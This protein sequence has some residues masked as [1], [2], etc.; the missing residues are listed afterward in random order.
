MVSTL[1]LRALAALTLMLPLVAG[2]GKPAQEAPAATTSATATASPSVAAATLSGRPASALHLDAVDFLSPQIGWLAA[3][4]GSTA[5]ILRTLTGGA[6]WERLAAGSNDFLSLDFIDPDT[7]WALVRAGSDVQIEHTADGGATWAVQWIGAAADMRYLME[8]EDA[9]I[10]MLDPQNGHA[11]FGGQLLATANGGAA[12]QPVTTL[13]AGFTPTGMAWRD[14]QHGWVAGMSCPAPAGGSPCHVGVLQ[15]SDG[16]ASWASDFTASEA[17]M[18]LAAGA[19]LP[20]LSFPTATQGWLYFKTA[21]LEGR[22]YAT[23]DGGAT[24][25]LEQ[26]NLAGGRGVAGLPVF[27]SPTTGW[28]PRD[29]GAAPQPGGI[30]VTHDSGRTWTWVG[31]EQGWS[32]TA[33]SAVSAKDG[34]AIGR[35]AGSPSATFLMQTSNGGATW[36]ESALTLRP[37]GAI[38]FLSASV[39]YGARSA[40]DPGAVL[41]STDGGATWSVRALLPGTVEAISFAD[42]QHGWAVDQPWPPSQ[43][44]LDVMA[45]SDGGATWREVAQMAQSSLPV[46]DALRFFDAQHGTLMIGAHPDWLVLTSADGGRTWTPVGH[47]AVTPGTTAVVTMP[48]SGDLL[49]LESTPALLRSEDGGVS[50][51]SLPELPAGLGRGIGL[52]AAGTK[53]VWVFLQS[54]ARTVLLRSANSGVSWSRTTLPGAMPLGAPLSVSAISGSAAWVLSGSGL[55]ATRD[56]G[57]TWT[58]LR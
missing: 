40:S 17:A 12:W 13:P 52:G 34:W 41:R 49:L 16:G 47:R 50:W 22:L 56:G 15:T 27:L 14:A 6:S 55:F 46:P 42:A 54:G 1:R 2:C 37:T 20:G 24:W 26:P 57:Q 32:I 11:L 43:Q 23:A 48:A 7:G 29:A 3:H 25:T 4:R 53:Y 8:V 35:R 45:T 10:E 58:W 36:S 44:L 38:D 51:A 21:S 9:R 31:A 33:L 18:P 19:G 5:D 39:G 28:L 30:Q